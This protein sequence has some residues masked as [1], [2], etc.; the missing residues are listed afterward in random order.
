MG[1]LNELV[2]TEQVLDGLLFAIQFIFE[3]F[4]F[5]LELDAIISQLVVQNFHFDC[6]VVQLLLFLHLES[7]LASLRLRGSI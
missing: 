6:L 2:V 4:Y 7:V 1:L 3:Y 5:G